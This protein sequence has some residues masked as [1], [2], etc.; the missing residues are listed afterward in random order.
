MLLSIV[1]GVRTCIKTGM[2][3]QSKNNRNVIN[4]I[5]N[6]KNIPVIIF[7]GMG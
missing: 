6:D 4:N 1:N 3:L 7:I 2:N 5:K